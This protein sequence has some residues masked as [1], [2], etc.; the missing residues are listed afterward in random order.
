MRPLAKDSGPRK[1]TT[2]R[3]CLMSMLRQQHTKYTPSRIQTTIRETHNHGW[4]KEQGYRRF[5]S[6]VLEPYNSPKPIT[7]RL[8]G[9]TTTNSRYSNGHTATT[10]AMQTLNGNEQHV[11]HA[12]PRQQQDLLLLLYRARHSENPFYG[13]KMLIECCQRRLTD[14]SL[15]TPETGAYVAWRISDNAVKLAHRARRWSNDIA[16]LNGTNGHDSIGTGILS[17]RTQEETLASRGLSASDAQILLDGIRY[18][19]GNGNMHSGSSF[20]EE[21]R[22]LASI[23]ENIHVLSLDRPATKAAY[24][25]LMKRLGIQSAELC[26]VGLEPFER[27]LYD[28]DGKYTLHMLALGAMA[29]LAAGMG[30]LLYGEYHRRN[31][32]PVEHCS[33]A[34][35]C[36]DIPEQSIKLIKYLSHLSTVGS[37]DGYG[38][39]TN[40]N[41]LKG[42]ICNTASIIIRNMSIISMEQLKQLIYSLARTT[43]VVDT[44]CLGHTWKALSVS[45]ALETLHRCEQS[46]QDNVESIGY[47]DLSQILSCGTA[48][49]GSIRGALREVTAQHACETEIHEAKENVAAVIDAQYSSYLDSGYPVSPD[50][51]W[52]VLKRVAENCIQIQGNFQSVGT[53]PSNYTLAA[54]DW[55]HS[56]NTRNALA[57]SAAEASCDTSDMNRKV[58]LARLLE[59]SKECG[60]TF[61]Y[62][63]SDCQILK[64]MLDVA[65]EGALDSR[66]LQQL[67]KILGTRSCK[68][69]ESGYEETDLKDEAASIRNVIINGALVS[70]ENAF[71]GRMGALALP[72]LAEWMHTIGSTDEILKSSTELYLRAIRCYGHNLENG[73]LNHQLRLCSALVKLKE[74]PLFRD[75]HI[76]TDMQRL[77][78]IIIDRSSSIQN[79][80]RKRKLERLIQKGLPCP[81]P[82]FADPERHA[83]VPHIRRQSQQCLSSSNPPR[84]LDCS[85]EKIREEWKSVL[86]CLRNTLQFVIDFGWSTTL[87]RVESTLKAVNDKTASVGD[88]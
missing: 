31:G 40:S 15:R 62:I 53:E 9:D 88:K 11:T 67:M 50:S 2:A 72:L 30:W 1:P 76:K 19:L 48:I 4:V 42:F 73:S 29:N 75:S 85:R 74:H 45:I 64:A 60:F 14:D 10:S 52:L 47:C 71:L 70:Q 41:P 20:G 44:S 34:S 56:N 25:N 84:E 12:K 66:S 7:V 59:T 79:L 87:K 39:Q 22:M 32:M 6:N 35:V 33:T 49:D 13:M 57:K 82:V 17:R 43:H 81:E 78:A 36:S 54:R 55:L 26:A 5:T 18:E 80:L 28:E 68:S 16:P 8:R 3:S 23:A 65:N 83:V 86:T 21:M 37:A 61:D 46:A 58:Q 51:I 24:R 63:Q 69:T 27:K 77:C 38:S